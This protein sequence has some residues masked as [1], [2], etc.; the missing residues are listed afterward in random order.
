M[1][2]TSST[3]S[4]QADAPGVPLPVEA[5]G[6]PRPA[7][8][9]GVPCPAADSRDAAVT[10]SEGFADRAR[11]GNATLLK[12]LCAATE[13]IDYARWTPLR[14]MAMERELSFD[15]SLPFGPLEGATSCSMD[16]KW[17]TFDCQGEP[18]AVGYELGMQLTPLADVPGKHV[19]SLKITGLCSD[20]GMNAVAVVMSARGRFTDGL[21][22][23]NHSASVAC[24]RQDRQQRDTPSLAESCGQNSVDDAWTHDV[25]IESQGTCPWENT[26]LTLV[27]DPEVCK[28]YA[29]VEPV[30]A[31]ASAAVRTISPEVFDAKWMDGA[32]PHIGILMSG[33]LGNRVDIV[34]AS[35][36]VVDLVMTEPMFGVT[37][38]VV[39]YH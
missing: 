2:C 31:V 33:T 24:Y 9:P 38:S 15:H 30:E 20:Y 10:T 18:Y 17:V 22:K 37:P 35:R 1:G 5:P 34:P 28:V 6:V 26:L 13:S 4:A 39:V 19:L 23:Q 14:P 29:Y 8:T 16:P 25:C 27:V 12:R 7:D 21:F 3:A 36:R 32:N 11:D